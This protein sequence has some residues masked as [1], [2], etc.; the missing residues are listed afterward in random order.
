[1]TEQQYNLIMGDPATPSNPN[2]AKVGAVLGSPSLPMSWNHIN[3]TFLVA[4]NSKVS[5]SGLT[6][7]FPSEAQWEFACRAGTR[8][9]YG[10]DQGPI[11]NQGVAEGNLSL[12]GW[13]S[14]NNNPP[15]LGTGVKEVGMKTANLAGLYDMH[16]NVLEWCLDQS[17][18][19]GHVLDL[20]LD[21]VSKNGSA[22]ILRGGDFSNTAASCRSA[23]R[24]YYMPVGLLDEH[25]P[26][27]RGCGCRGSMMCAG[28]RG[29]DEPHEWHARLAARGDTRPPSL[30][31]PDRSTG[32]LVD[33]PTG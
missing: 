29:S 20:T 15:N 1:L 5:S 26:A 14:G 32:R 31:N 25:W 28:G 7:N 4:L 19:S 3:T 10:D 18:G 30:R 23:S 22:N 21:Y 8:G 24:N 27:P 9:T 12:I 11:S 33:R 2:R 17:D 13:W 6:L 16:G